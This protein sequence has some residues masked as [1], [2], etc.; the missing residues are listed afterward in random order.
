VFAGHL[1]LVI[2]VLGLHIES[3]QLGM[4]QHHNSPKAEIVL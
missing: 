2:P 4:K 3:G 1:I